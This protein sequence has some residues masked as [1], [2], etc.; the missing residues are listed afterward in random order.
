MNAAARRPERRELVAP[1]DRLRDALRDRVRVGRVDQHRGAVGDLLHRRRTARHDR[2]AARERLEHGD[3]ESLVQR[4]VRDAERASVQR[5]EL[6]VGYEAEEADAVAVH[7]HVTPAARAG[8]A[9]LDARAP[10]SPRRAAAGSCAA[11][12]FPTAST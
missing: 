2:R 11:R 5:G 9:E 3:T 8:D 4:R 7:A 12:P 1:T 10:G 6:L